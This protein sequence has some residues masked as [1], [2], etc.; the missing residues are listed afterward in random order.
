MKITEVFTPKSSAI[1]PKMYVARPQ[2][3][4]KLKRAIERDFHTLIY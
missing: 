1:N 2:L 3:E 4:S